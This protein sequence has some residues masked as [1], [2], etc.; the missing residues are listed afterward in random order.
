MTR[1]GETHESNEGMVRATFEDIA[2]AGEGN[3]ILVLLR[4]EG[5]DIVYMTIDALQA[6]SIAAGRAK[7]KFPRP[8]THDLILSILEILDA[9]ILRIE[10]TNLANSTYYAKLVLEAR[11]IEYD[12]DCRPSDALALAVRMDAPLF[13]AQKVVD[14]AG[15]TDFEGGSGGVEA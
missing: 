15:M 7:E 12:I 14:V 10:V 2:V 6:M 9:R 13:I 3:Q 8:L 1:E 11:G 5:G 4:T